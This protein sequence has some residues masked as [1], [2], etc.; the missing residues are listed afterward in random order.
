MDEIKVTPDHPQIADDGEGTI[1]VDCHVIEADHPAFR[2]VEV[3]FHDG[4]PR[5]S[6]CG[7]WLND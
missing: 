7:D 5:C 6:G 4:E 2:W 3:T 1:A